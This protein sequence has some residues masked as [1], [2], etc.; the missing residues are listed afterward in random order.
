MR[1]FKRLAVFALASV[2][3]ASVFTACG[4]S[5]DDSNKAGEN[6][7]GTITIKILDYTHIL[8]FAQQNGQLDQ[9]FEDYDVELEVNELQSGPIA[10]EAFAAGEADFAVMGHMPAITGIASDYGVKIIGIATKSDYSG[11]VVVPA[12]SDVSSIEDLKGKKVGTYI[13]GSWHY[14]LSVYLQNVGLTLDDIELLN[15]TQETASGIRT[16][17]LDAG[18]I[19]PDT[20]LVLV[21][22]GSGKVIAETPGEPLYA[23]ISASEEFIADHPD[24]TKAYLKA[25]KGSYEY[26]NDNLDD[27]F[28]Y[29]EEQTGTTTDSLRATWDLTDRT[30]RSFDDS[31]IQAIDNLIEW[32]KNEEFIS[33]DIKADDA[34]DDTLIKEIEAE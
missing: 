21:N 16:G 2:I 15:T 18:V 6:E 28:A 14:I 34:I 23:T 19:G 17:E 13:G 20:A 27:Y 31:D 7:D 22:E 26:I 3:G 9:Y 1:K 32:M 24:L 10:N 11:T 8:D 25:L 30:V 5:D 4:K 29:Y 33:S 12:D